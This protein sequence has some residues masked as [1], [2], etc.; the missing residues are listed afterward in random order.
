M[1]PRLT[2]PLRPVLTRNR[3]MLGTLDRELQVVRACG[4]FEKLRLGERVPL[5]FDIEPGLGEIEMPSLTLQ[6]LLENAVVWS[7]A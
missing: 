6:L 5:D 4:E 2:V 1:S 7:C 3:P